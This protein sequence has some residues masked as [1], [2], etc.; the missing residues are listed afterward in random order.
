VDEIQLPIELPADF[1]EEVYLQ[2]NPDVWAAIKNGAFRSGRE[3]WLEH[4]QFEKRPYR[5]DFQCWPEFDEATYLQFNPDVVD[6]IRGGAFHSGYE[7]W[8]DRGRLE[9]RMGGAPRAARALPRPPVNGVNYFG[10]YSQPTGLGSATRGYSAAFASQNI[11]LSAID[12]PAW[13][14]VMDR[15][16]E[17]GNRAPN[18]R[19][20]VN[21]I[22]QNPDMMPL[23]RKYYGEGAMQQGYNI[24]MWVW[25]L[26]A[27]QPR[28]HAIS[29]LLDEIWVPSRFCMHAICPVSAAP[30]VHM[31]H[32]IVPPHPLA[33]HNRAHFGI[34]EDRFVFLYVFD[35]GSGLQ[36]KNPHA[37][38]RA[39]RNAFGDRDDVLLLLKYSFAELDRG[40]A[41]VFEEQAQGPNI[42]LLSGTL[43]PEEIA[44]LYR[45]SNCFVSPHR[46]E[47]FGCN[48]AEA[49][50]FAKPVI[51]TGYSGNMDFTSADNS[52]LIDFTLT[53]IPHPIGPYPQNGVWAD[54]S[55]S[56]LAALL[57][58]VVEEPAEAAAK[59]IKAMET[60]EATL[61]PAI[62]GRQMRK[63]LEIQQQ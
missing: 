30:L 9:G 19:Y 47:G 45:V 60:V 57:R 2:L 40:G 42:R 49:M 46:A 25:E 1:E 59:G 18:L 61:K 58:R 24:G 20:N 6:A 10:F 37:L 3:H 43:T 56:H 39:F 41:T 17:W 27:G 38:I 26:A 54:P 15:Q 34:P 13:H 23:F 63:Q 33:V 5:R 52:Y 48:I 36:R 28:W 12:V 7:H 32:A 31:P 14:T 11:P 21:F 51:V 4:G 53:Q 16:E 35:V 44:S 50:Y 8:L 29:R 55:I 22:H 62:I